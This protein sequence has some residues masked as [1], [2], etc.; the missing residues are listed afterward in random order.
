MQT[1]LQLVLVA[2][3]STEN[4]TVQTEK[5]FLQD[6]YCSVIGVIP[7][8]F[9]SIS[10]ICTSAGAESST[11]GVQAQ[12][13]TGGSEKPEEDFPTKKPTEVDTV[14]N[15]VKDRQCSGERIVVKVDRAARKDLLNTSVQ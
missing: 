2:W 15:A 14:M 10:C 6:N 11:A 4:K 12:E 7:C 3:C 8:T 13:G 9:L 5:L 1:N